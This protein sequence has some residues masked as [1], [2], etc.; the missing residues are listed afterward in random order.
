MATNYTPVIEVP[1]ASTSAGVQLALWGY[2][3]SNC[4]KWN[5]TG[6]V[7]SATI[8][9][10]NEAVQEN[11]Q[12]TIYP[13]PASSIIN[14]EGVKAGCAYK[15]YSITGSLAKQGTIVS[16]SIDISALTSGLYYLTI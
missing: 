10:F 4:Q 8:G 12:I 1:G 16:S 2:N 13:S 15:I 11:C 6:T 14:L 3:G 7:K 5:F 9:D